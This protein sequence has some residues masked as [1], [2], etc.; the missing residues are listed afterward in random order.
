MLEKLAK[1]EENYVAMEEKLADP[2]VI[3]NS[4]E[5]TKL[6]KEYKNL[7]P[8]IEKYR[9]YKST[10]AEKDGAFALMNEE[11]GEL[12]ELAEAE[13]Y[14][15]KDELE[16]LGATSSEAPQSTEEEISKIKIVNP[17]KAKKSHGGIIID[18]E[19]GCQVKFARCCNPLPGDKIVGF[20]TRG[21]GV[22]KLAGILLMLVALVCCFTVLSSAAESTTVILAGDRLRRYFPD[23]TMTPREIEESV[24][25]ALEE[26]RQRQEKLKQ[27]NDVSREKSAKKS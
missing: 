8:I 22:S 2:E 18:G 14:E 26:R 21:F 5:Y 12:A 24:Y 9:I 17:S 16:K 23:V 25:E 3:S 1:A 19:P 7:T 20:I 11:D 4:E 6:M 13:Y 10:E 15:K 27:K